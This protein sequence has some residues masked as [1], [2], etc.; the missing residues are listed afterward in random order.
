MG[1]DSLAAQYLVVM[2]YSFVFVI[3]RMPG[4]NREKY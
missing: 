2:P 4:K 3:Y 1:Y